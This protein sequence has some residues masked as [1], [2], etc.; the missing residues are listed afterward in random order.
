MSLPATGTDKL[1][2]QRVGRIAVFECDVDDGA[3][4]KGLHLPAGNG[5]FFWLVGIVRSH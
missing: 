2:W 4:L 1:R 3:R 5:G